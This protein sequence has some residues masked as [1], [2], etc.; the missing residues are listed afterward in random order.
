MI[1]SYFAERVEEK[2]IDKAELAAQGKAVCEQCGKI[3]RIDMV[4]NDETYGTVCFACAE[5][6]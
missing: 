3:H 2:V 6:M 4:F 5:L 1:D